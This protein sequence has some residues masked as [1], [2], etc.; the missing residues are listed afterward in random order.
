M[1]PSSMCNKV[2]N[3]TYWGRKDTPFPQSLFPKIT[4]PLLVIASLATC[5]LSKSSSL[6]GHIGQRKETPRLEKRL[7]SSV[8]QCAAVQSILPAQQQKISVKL[9]PVPKD[10]IKSF[11]QIAL[12]PVPPEGITVELPIIDEGG[13]RNTRWL[14]SILEFVSAGT[15]FDSILTQKT[16]YSASNAQAQFRNIVFTLRTGVMQSDEGAYFRKGQKV[17]S[18]PIEMYANFLVS[19][20]TLKNPR[21]DQFFINKEFTG[22]HDAVEYLMA[23]LEVFKWEPNMIDVPG[24]GNCLFY[25]LALAFKSHNVHGSLKNN[26]NAWANVPLDASQETQFKGNGSS[27]D[28]Q[29]VLAAGQE[30]REISLNWLQANRNN[31]E[32]HTALLSAVTDTEVARG[33]LL[34]SATDQKYVQAIA[35]KWQ[36]LDQLKYGNKYHDYLKASETLNRLERSYIALLKNVQYGA[37]YK[38]I[39]LENLSHEIVSLKQ[40]I[41]IDLK[42][43]LSEEF[44]KAKLILDK[45]MDAIIE[46]RD[47]EKISAY[48]E[49]TAQKD[50]FCGT[51]QI[52]ALSHVFN[53]PINVIYTDGQMRTFNAKS[54]HF[55]V[56]I[57]HVNGNHFTFV[58]TRKFSLAN[59]FDL[60][61]ENFQANHSIENIPTEMHKT[62]LQYFEKM[63]A[64]QE[65]SNQ[66]TGKVLPSPLGNQRLA[67]HRDNAIILKGC[68]ASMENH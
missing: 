53:T 36:A 35:E 42:Q 40:L 43:P 63:S 10:N 62:L 6:L 20:K 57:A 60:H 21:T 17:E 59:D 33:S 56:T 27:S 30:L 65:K 28:K 38:T 8:S 16:T 9:I 54:G 61:L 3:S 12:P 48:L 23:F 58:P 55:P 68:I 45:E 22:R 31:P 34:S 2:F 49:K 51:A 7:K 67:T 25:S 13:F 39:E 32:I 44:T 46:K 52:L 37:Y 14:N 24:D 29:K 1:D 41:L 11:Q 26:S 4:Y 15:E 50:F 66:H 5:A 18:I 19:L 64:L 47:A